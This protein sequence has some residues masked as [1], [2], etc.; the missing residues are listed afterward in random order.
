MRKEKNMANN[1]ERLQ[2]M[3]FWFSFPPNLSNNSQ[4]LEESPGREEA[5]TRVNKNI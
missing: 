2:N 5:A 3:S 4:T 1:F